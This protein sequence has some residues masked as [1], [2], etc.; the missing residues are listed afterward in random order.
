MPKIYKKTSLLLLLC[1]LISCD[2]DGYT[3]VDEYFALTL[4]AYSD[5]G[6]GK[7]AC[8]VNGKVWTV[9]GKTYNN[10]I[11]GGTEGWQPNEANVVRFND[12]LIKVFGSS[13][14]VN[15]DQTRLRET[16][17]FEFSAKDE[18]AGTYVL[19]TEKDIASYV[20]VYLTDPTEYR[21]SFVNPMVITMKRYDSGIMS[22]T[23]EGY[24]TNIENAN[25][26]IHITRG[27]FDV[28]Y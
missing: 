25:D 13:S 3:N 21:S 19:N 28:K 16:F 24:M 11:Y 8:L 7:F 20:K 1:F 22:A 12:N 14:L 10:G 18:T 17:I 26:S 15:S 4:P 27:F 2:D 23:F 9:F 5:T 6:Q